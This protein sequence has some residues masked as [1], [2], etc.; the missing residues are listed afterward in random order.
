MVNLEPLRR[1]KCEALV[2]ALVGKD[3]AVKWWQSPNKAFSM[4]TPE[5]I[6]K[7]AP[8]RV[9]QYLMSHYDGGGS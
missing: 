2:V 9:Y 7:H 6:Y 3:L 4:H 5:V 8:D 1:Q